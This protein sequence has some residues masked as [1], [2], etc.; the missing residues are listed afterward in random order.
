MPKPIQVP[1]TIAGLAGQ[2]LALEHTVY[3]FLQALT[4]KQRRA[5]LEQLQSAIHAIG[6][7]Q[8]NDPT[9]RTVKKSALEQ[10]GKIRRVLDN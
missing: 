3:A 6:T 8:T 9:S 2:M 7:I 5:I 4:P 1:G 10:I